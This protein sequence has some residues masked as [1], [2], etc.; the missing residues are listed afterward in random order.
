MPK[1]KLLLSLIMLISIIP[2]SKASVSPS[3]FKTYLSEDHPRTSKENLRIAQMRF[4]T[5]L[6]LKEYQTLKGKKLNFIER[7]L[8]KASQQ[9]MNKMLKAYDDGDGPTILQK[10][11]WYLKGL[12]LGPI[13]VLL[14][15][16]FL[17]DEERE[18]IKWT[19]FGFIGFVAAVI[20]VIVSLSNTR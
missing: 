11:S 7:K 12:V 20:L 14:A 15:Y 19:W 8:F 10:M 17:K 1:Q 13:A 5:S 4:Y 2:F 18:L 9:R 16:I 6:S 3:S